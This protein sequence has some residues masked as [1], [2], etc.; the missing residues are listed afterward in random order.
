M[1]AYLAKWLVV[2][3]RPGYVSLLRDRRPQCLA[4]ERPLRMNVPEQ[5]RQL[6]DQQQCRL[7]AEVPP[8]RQLAILALLR[9]QDR[10]P[11]SRGIELPT[12]PTPQPSSDL[13]TGRSVASLGA[14][15][16]L[17]L[18]FEATGDGAEA[19]PA[20]PTDDLV[21]WGKRFLQE[22]AW[23]AEAEQVLTHCETGFMRIVDDGD[24]TFGAWIAAKRAP[25]NWRERADFDWWA[26]WLTMCH[27]NEIRA[28][29]SASHD[30]DDDTFYRQ[31]ANVLLKTMAYQHGYPPS[32]T[33]GG[34]TIQT[35]CDVLGCLLGWALQARDRGETI[36]PQP[37][38]EHALI[39]ALASALAVDQ[40][41]IGRAVAALTL[42]GENAADHSA[43]PGV[44]AAPL[45]RIAPN[46]I[47]WS[48]H[49]LMTEP[50]LFLTR[51][52]RRCHAQEYHNTAS[53]RESVFRE[54][55]YGLFQD[56]RFV[57][58]AGR[59]ELR[60]DDGKILTDID[61]VIFDRKTGTLGIFELKSQ[62]PFARSIAE[63]ERRRDNVLYANHQVSG[64]LDWMNRHGPDNLLS[65]VDARTA[66]SFRANKVYPFVLGRYLVHFNDGPEPNR[67]A[68]WGT[69][70]GILRLLDGKP[71]RA[72]DANP[73]ASLSTRLPKD[74]PHILPPTDVP[75]REIS[76]G[77]ARIV[78]HPSYASFQAGVAV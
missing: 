33:I 63:L 7:Q 49:G 67:R 50:L 5:L 40:E 52:L 71:V 64:V 2:W 58:S 69:W 20:S 6:I 13:V 17:H 4:T 26:A 39:S 44:A 76:I 9:I 38:S 34:C 36:G 15:K 75:P 12:P 35:Y 3:Q 45:V 70:P 1:D 41:I 62:D 23:L 78:V 55:L 51:E 59:V 37:Q 19:A 18:C 73:L 68:A 22:C 74:V 27:E 29:H 42:D 66:K 30:P 14:N 57:T 77:G 32:A 72:T 25:A 16:A 47:V 60:R 11:H 24:G 46:R 28:L 21:G 43:V 65:R 56:K 48:I 31:L 54:D 61:A 8:D 10:L 53:L